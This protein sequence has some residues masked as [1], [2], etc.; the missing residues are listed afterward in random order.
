MR[1]NLYS[2]TAVLLPRQSTPPEQVCAAY[3]CCFLLS[4]FIRP[5]GSLQGSPQFIPVASSDF[6]YAVIGWE[7]GCAGCGIVIVFIWCSSS[8]VTRV[9]AGLPPRSAGCLPQE[10]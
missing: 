3:A 7:L 4:I 5:P 2:I 6:V 10:L 1:K 8:A 9:R